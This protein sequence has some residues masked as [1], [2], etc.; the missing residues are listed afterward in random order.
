MAPGAVVALEIGAAQAQAVS[1][2]ALE[3]GLSARCF[4]DLGGHNRCLLLTRSGH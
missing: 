1:A 2:L 4:Q 3:A